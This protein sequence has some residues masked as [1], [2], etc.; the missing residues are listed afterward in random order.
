MRVAPKV[1]LSPEQAVVLEQRSRGRSIP[2]RVV[3]RARI[4]LLAAHS[5]R[6][7]EVCGWVN[8]SA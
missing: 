6:R 3:E 8:D 1:E 7:V 2:A 5:K 4:I